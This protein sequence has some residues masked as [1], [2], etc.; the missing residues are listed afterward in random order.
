MAIYIYIHIYIYIYI[1]IILF[2]LSIKHVIDSHDQAARRPDGTLSCLPPSVASVIGDGWKCFPHSFKSQLKHVRGGFPMASKSVGT[3][4]QS[5]GQKM[6][7]QKLGRKLLELRAQLHTPGKHDST[8]EPPKE[9]GRNIEHQCHIAGF[10][11]H[12]A[13]GRATTQMRSQLNKAI[14]ST[15]FPTKQSRSILSKSGVVICVTAATPSAPLAA[16]VFGPIAPPLII[17]SWVHLGDVSLSPHGFKGQELELVSDSKPISSTSACGEVQLAGMWVFKN[18][19]ELCRDLSKA[20]S[21]YVR[22]FG[23]YSSSRLL[24][25]LTA[26]RCTVQELQHI[27]DAA[28]IFWRGSSDVDHTETRHSQQLKRDAKKAA[29]AGTH[30]CCSIRWGYY[31]FIWFHRRGL[32]ERS[33]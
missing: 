3:L 20:L 12:G 16:G 22:F 30:N 19:W 1:Y 2:L 8:P 4:A 24:G 32:W 33:G 25:T 15:K 6:L 13:A 31:C 11:V 28:I 26:S 7:P 27:G 21:W 14:C 5:T 17:N 23:F 18:E 29:E 9:A 10:C